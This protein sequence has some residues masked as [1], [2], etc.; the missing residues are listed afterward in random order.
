MGCIKKLLKNDCSKV[1]CSSRFYGCSPILWLLPGLCLRVTQHGYPA[2][3]LSGN[4]SL[5]Y[6]EVSL[7]HRSFFTLSV[8]LCFKQVLRKMNIFCR[9]SSLLTKLKWM[10]NWCLKRS[11]MGSSV[12]SVGGCS[13][14][15]EGNWAVSEE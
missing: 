14:S 2:D 9:R 11:Q 15:Q 1:L 4:S 7:H 13:H 3:S 12:Q 8:L 5:V 6:L 10:L